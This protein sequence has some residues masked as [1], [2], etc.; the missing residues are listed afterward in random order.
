MSMEYKGYTARVV[1]DA[2]AEVLH[3]EVDGLRDVVTFE[4]TSVKALRAAFQQSVDDYLALCATRGEQPDRAYSGKLL[5]RMEP[6]LHRVLSNT[7][8]ATD[9]SLNTLVVDTLA[10]KANAFAAGV[11]PEPKDRP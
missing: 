8:R 11:L 10:L 3:G 7:A 6:Y 9:T 2:D 5:V 4:A 1:C